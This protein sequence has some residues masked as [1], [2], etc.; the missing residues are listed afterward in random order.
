MTEKDTTE[1]FL[2]TGGALK[3]T[4]GRE[5]FGGRNKTSITIGQV[6]ANVRILERIG[7][8]GMGD[9]FSGVDKRL[10]RKVAV[11][12]LLSGSH[13]TASTKL[14]F[15][16]EAKI[17][18]RLDHPG[19]CRLYD[20][21]EEED[22]SCLML[23][24]VDGTPLDQLAGSLDERG[25]LDI[26]LQ[27]AEA[28]AA[29][30]REGIVHR[31]VKPGN[32]IV[33]ADS[34]TKVLDFGIG[35]L[36]EDVEVEM[37]PSL[38]NERSNRLSTATAAGSIIGTPRFMSPEQARGEPATPA[39]DLFSLGL[40]LCALKTGQSPIAAEDLLEA[41]QAAAEARC[42]IP[43]NFSPDLRRLIGDLTKADPSERPTAAETAERLRS[44][45]E[46]PHKRRRRIVLGVGA[47]AVVAAIVGAVVVGKNVGEGRY[48]CQ[49]FERYL[50]GVWDPPAEERLAQ[51]FD[52][53][54]GTGVFTMVKPVLDAYVREWVDLRSG[55]CE[56]TWIRGEQSPEMLDLEN[57]CFDRRLQELASLIEVFENNPEGTRSK[58]G[59]AVHALTPPSVCLDTR[60]LSTT[61]PLPEDPVKRSLVADSRRDL[62]R[63]KALYDTGAYPEGWGAVQEIEAGI[64][65]TNYK[66]LN[67]E[68]LYLKAL[69]AEKHGDMHMARSTLEE[70]ILAGEA[71]RH[72]RLVAQAWI[73]SVWID[74]IILND[75][76]S[77][78]LDQQF[79]RAALERNGK[80]FA[81]EGALA[82]HISNI[83]IFN[84]V[85]GE[86][87]LKHCFEAL[88]LRR[89]AFGPK[90]PKVASTMQ[91]CARML[92]GLDR[93]DESL[94]LTREAYEMRLET[95]G[96]EHPSVLIS[97]NGL[98]SA[99]IDLDRIDEA[100]E[101]E[102]EAL[103]LAEKSYP[104][105]HPAIAR[106]K[107][108]VANAYLASGNFNR[109]IQ[110]SREAAESLTTSLGP[111]S[112]ATGDA[113]YNLG[114]AAR[115]IDPEDWELCR[116]ASARSRD[117]FLKKLGPGKRRVIKAEINLGAALSALGNHE[118]AVETLSATLA[119]AERSAVEPILLN[120]TRITLAKALIDGHGDLDRARSILETALTDLKDRQDPTADSIVQD[121]G[122]MMNEL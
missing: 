76:E 90:H 94:A 100:I 78:A 72:D 71:G 73:R 112:I 88:D 15:L 21:V 1:A 95:L 56:S 65:E 31:D 40:T 13:L 9:V 32:V 120:I 60:L 85:L 119:A 12:T 24:F 63:I 91:N 30:H 52:S 106:I 29:A 70:A 115:K 47:L 23:E 122:N 104:T 117:I 111:D 18:S 35:R 11:K 41:L 4:L 82:N 36:M 105:G 46:A 97:L 28:L 84:P 81:L 66:P 110:L 118:P 33:T 45:I 53:V 69:L 37:H 61:I 116:E 48:R 62:A 8:G 64:L 51:S 99:L 54:G 113:W 98:A 27:V 50:K 80:D 75:F 10:G 20:L 86:Q 22:L 2:R 57:A 39:S 83:E 55:A 26:G 6:I 44:I 96:P 108:N 5:A 7:T 67:A 17:L 14:R 42:D 38:G 114:L 16:N 107:N 93:V 25:I 68:F 77:A 92:A 101:L 74:G 43:S 121:I 58:A 109:A 34:M 89:Q 19:I 79:A 3:G 102:Q 49:D 103:D 59:Q 87:A